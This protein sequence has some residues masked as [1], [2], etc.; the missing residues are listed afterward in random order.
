MDAT[1]LSVL[2]SGLLRAGAP[3]SAPRGGADRR[4][5]GAST[6]LESAVFA[7]LAGA[8]PPFPD[9]PS[10]VP[11]VGPPVRG[12]AA[13]ARVSSTLSFAVPVVLCAPRTRLPGV[14]PGLV[15]AGEFPAL[16]PLLLRGTLL[17][18]RCGLSG[19]GPPSSRDARYRAVVLV[20]RDAFS[21]LAVSEER[22]ADGAGGRRRRRSR[23]FRAST[24]AVAA[25]GTDY[26][27]ARRG[28]GRAFRPDEAAQSRQGFAT[29][30]TLFF[31]GTR[32]CLPWTRRQPEFHARR[33]A[34]WKEYLYRWSRADA[35]APRDA[36]SWRRFPG[37]PTPT[38]CGGR[39]R[40]PGRAGL[41]RLR[42]SP[43]FR[44]ILLAKITFRAHRGIGRRD[45]GPLP[46]RRFLRGMV[47]SIC[48]VL[49]A[50]RAGNSVPPSG[51]WACCWRSGRPAAPV[52]PRRRRSGLT[53]IR[54]HYEGL[55]VTLHSVI[56]KDNLATA[57]DAGAG[58][59][60]TRST[61]SA[62]SAARRDHH[63]RQRPL[64]EAAR[65]AA[66]RRAPRRDRLGARGG[67]DL[68]PARA[69]RARRST[70]SR[71]RTGS[72]RASRS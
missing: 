14:S 29:A 60:R 27:R 17:E 5:G 38:G 4:S 47:R 69:R 21:R 39:A 34:A 36:L 32:A 66:R 23:V 7:S 31:P 41:R 15:S 12:A 49:A 2:L 22:S 8:S 1:G 40:A 19:R 68:R 50:H 67:R 54:V 20:R 37:G 44:R 70:R 65:L 28:S 43:A 57:R 6:D 52:A 16:S 53:L 72:G 46:G 25:G 11:A 10:L 26:R 42:S 64:G 56:D 55:P 3:R 58:A 30:S 61:S 62:A 18:R 48:G 63:G 71:S 35:I 33:D 9:A 24:R 45:P 51:S 13:R 59:P